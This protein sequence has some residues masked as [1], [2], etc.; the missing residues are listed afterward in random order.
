MKIKINILTIS[1]SG[2]FSRAMRGFKA[3]DVNVR[4]NMP[5]PKTLKIGDKIK[6]IHRPTEWNNAKWHVYAKDKKFMDILI[7]RGYWQRISEIDEYDKPWIHVKIKNKNKIVHH[8]WAITE[9]TG[10]LRKNK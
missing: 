8:N 10:W 6:F 3:A 2:L 9:K 1:S 7:A 4:N 5:N